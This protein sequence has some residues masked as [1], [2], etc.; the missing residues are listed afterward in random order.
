MNI[1]ISILIDG[2]IFS[3]WLF[4][5]SAGLTL[6]YGI[7]RVLNFAHGSI[8]TIGAYTSAFLIGWYFTGNYPPY[9][10]YAIFLGGAIVAGG[11][12]GIVI[13]RS[14][15]QWVYGYGEITIALITYGI[16]MIL[17]ALTK[18]VFGV[19][20]YVAYQPSRLLGRTQIMGVTHTNYNLALI[21]VAATMSAFLWFM[22]NKTKIGKLLHV[23]TYDREISQAL[24]INIKRAF[25][26]AFIIGNSL[27]ALAGGLI[28]P[29]LSVV[30]GLSAHVIILAIAVI[31]IGGLGSVKGAMIG[32][33]MIGIGHTLAVYIFPSFQLFVIYSIMVVVLIVHPSGLFPATAERKI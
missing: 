14:I 30:P 12:C 2:L 13:E 17:E 21:A 27:G 28:A 5:I 1:A 10:S 3:S 26:I 16:M 15:L 9:G 6:E 8:F 33:L 20:A 31:V 25:L 29:T 11:L 19:N 4:I 32:S 18:L 7:M 23:V 22:L 24:G